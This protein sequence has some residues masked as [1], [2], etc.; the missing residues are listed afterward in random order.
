M[1]KNRIEHSLIGEQFIALYNETHSKVSVLTSVTHHSVVDLFFTSYHL[2]QEFINVAAVTNNLIDHNL[3]LMLPLHI[4][5]TAKIIQ[6]L[7]EHYIN[8]N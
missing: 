4:D 5:T 8:R 2:L 7:Q 1:V 6:K 3:F